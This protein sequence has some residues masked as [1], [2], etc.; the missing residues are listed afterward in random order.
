MIMKK[1][2]E[3]KTE[4]KQ[5]VGEEEVGSQLPE[6]LVKHY[7]SVGMALSTYRSGKLP[8]VCCHHNLK[9]QVSWTAG[10]W[11]LV[12]IILRT[13]LLSTFQTFKLIPRLTNWED[14][15]DVMSPDKW[16]A[17]AMFQATRM[18]AS[19]MSEGITFVPIVRCALICFKIN[20]RSGP[21][22]L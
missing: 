4:V 18:F 20:S 13:H 5:I 15:L 8:K 2:E 1:I 14:I 9:R 21:A 12:V 3:K 22:I 10:S 7:S 16:S 19:N 17:A 6:E 11:D